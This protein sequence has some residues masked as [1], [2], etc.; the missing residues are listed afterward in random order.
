MWQRRSDRSAS[1]DRAVFS[2][3]PP[4]PAT[5]HIFYSNIM[6]VFRLKAQRKLKSIVKRKSGQSSSTVSKRPLEGYCVI[7]HTPIAATTAGTNWAYLFASYNTRPSHPQLRFSIYSG[8]GRARTISRCGI[9]GTGRQAF[10][11]SS[12][13]RGPPAKESKGSRSILK[14]V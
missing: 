7:W 1:A 4:R 14:V 2:I 5:I 12:R 6:D 8:W 10:P 11:T 9:R 13:S 3:L